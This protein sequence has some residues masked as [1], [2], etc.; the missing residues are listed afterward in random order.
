M[1]ICVEREFDEFCPKSLNLG[2]MFQKPMRFVSFMMAILLWVGAAS[3]TGKTQR[4][5]F[6]TQG[7]CEAC[8]PLIEQ[9]LQD[10]AGVDS[11]GWDFE[12][13]LTTVK[14]LPH[15]VSPDQLQQQLART[16]F[17]TQFYPADA[18]AQS[19]LPAC[20]QESINRKLKERKPAH[21]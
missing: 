21:P 17:E 1:Y 5:I 20:C 19:K 12:S 13:S 4:V 14:Y 3:C 7:N 15:Q 10:L 18:E 8:K 9:S 2:K 11:V 6:F 16:G